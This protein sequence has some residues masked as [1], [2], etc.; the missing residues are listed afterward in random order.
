MQRVDRFCPLSVHCCSACATARLGGFL[1]FARTRSGDK[2][3]PIPTLPALAPERGGSTPHRSLASI[4]RNDGPCP[5]LFFNGSRAAARD[6]RHERL[7]GAAGVYDKN[8]TS[9]S[10]IRMRV[11]RELSVRDWMPQHLQVVSGSRLAAGNAEMNRN[12][13][14]WLHLSKQECVF[15]IVR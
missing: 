10:N 12:T 9:T 4:D 14:F 5:T 3:A 1:P 11:G 13:K 15:G 7:S 2:V 8:T 6:T